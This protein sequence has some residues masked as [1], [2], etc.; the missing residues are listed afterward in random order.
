MS[1]PRY[2][3]SYLANPISSQYLQVTFGINAF[4]G[5]AD[6]DVYL[7]VDAYAQLG[8]DVSGGSGD[9]DLTAGLTINGGADGNFFDLIKPNVDYVIYTKT[10]PWWNVSFKLQTLPQSE[11][12]RLLLLSTETRGSFTPRTR[13][14]I[15]CSPHP[16]FPRCQLL[17]Q[18]QRSYQRQEED[19][20]VI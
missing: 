1:F 6:V 10:W 9:L 11:Q 19:G 8:V 13:P 12:N 5:K 20:L 15:P 17:L 18:L 4:D 14:R 16:P 3:V 7:N 2:V